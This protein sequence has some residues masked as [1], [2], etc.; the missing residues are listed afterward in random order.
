MAPNLIPTFWWYSSV[1]Y[2]LWVWA[3]FTDSLLIEYGRSNGRSLPIFGYKNTVAS[4]F[5]A[6]FFSHILSLWRSSAA[7]LWAT[8]EWRGQGMDISSQQPTTTQGWPTAVW[9]NLEA[10]P[11]PSSLEMS[12]APANYSL[13]R[14]SQPGVTNFLAIG[15]V[16]QSV[17][18]VWAMKFGG[19]LLRSNR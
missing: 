5:C 7:I 6:L 10:N 9:V 2:S 18:I 15:M 11:P 17:V 3:G 8:A 4:I 12:T 1:I 16:K 13:M 19:N 14:D